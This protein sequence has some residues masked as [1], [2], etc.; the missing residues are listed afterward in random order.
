MVK[1]TSIKHLGLK[2]RQIT[3]E[4]SLHTLPL[5]TTAFSLHP[6]Q[7][8]KLVFIHVDMK[9]Q[10]KKK[11]SPLKLFGQ[12]NLI[13]PR[14]AILYLLQKNLFQFYLYKTD[15]GETITKLILKRFF[16]SV[17][18]GTMICDSETVLTQ[19]LGCFFEESISHVLLSFRFCFR[20]T[21]WASVT[22]WQHIS[23]DRCHSQ[24]HFLCVSCIFAA[25]HLI[26][27]EIC[28]PFRGT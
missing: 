2:K 16:F 28:H 12:I 14:M 21:R 18:Q 13:V 4:C 7:H 5:W 17:F 19:A 10:S 6:L 26:S 3:E 22:T 25:P 27:S 8:K 23:T 15:W 9:G 24:P 1:A 11:K 20:L